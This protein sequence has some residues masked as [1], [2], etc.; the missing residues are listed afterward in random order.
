MDFEDSPEEAKFR[1]EVRGWLSA[2]AK[3][4]TKRD[5]ADMM[6]E[7]G[8]AAQMVASRA[9]QKTK[10]EAGYAR[11]TWPKGMGGIGGTPMQSII[12][13]QEESKFDVAT[14]GPFAIG[15]GMCI[16]TKS[17]DN[18]SYREPSPRETSRHRVHC[19]GRC[20]LRRNC[21]T[22]LLFRRST[23]P[24]IWPKITARS[25][26]SCGWL[27]YLPSRRSYLSPPRTGACFSTVA[28]GSHWRHRRISSSR[29]AR[30]P[31]PDIP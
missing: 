28:S 19:D 24:L 29:R 14:G 5:T 27:V 7:N 13:G 26:R 18:R 15:L 2:N 10:A 8:A 6:E 30:R 4:R 12:F 31:R 11:I 17:L 1:A 9:W 20:S 3:P 21:W 25:A 16:P 23:S 22:L